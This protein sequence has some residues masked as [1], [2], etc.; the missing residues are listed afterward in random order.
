MEILKQMLDSIDQLNE[1]R[2]EFGE[3]EYTT[4]SGWKAAAK[5][6]NK[7]V[8]FDGDKDIAQAMVGTK[9][10]KSGETRAIG[11]WDGEKGV[12]FSTSLKKEKDE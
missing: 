6:A 10:F 9:P 8:W 7:D 4:F 5:K 11:D 3:V 2:N 1:I 12:I